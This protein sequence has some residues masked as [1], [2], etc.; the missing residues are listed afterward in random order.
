MFPP[1]DLHVSLSRT[2]PVQ[3]HCI[4]PL[5]DAVRSKVSLRTTF[6]LHLSGIAVYVNDE[7]TRWEW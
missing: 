5:V 6:D 4:E 7:K 2:V 1:S 3:H